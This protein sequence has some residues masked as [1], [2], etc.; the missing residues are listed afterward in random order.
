MKINPII[1]KNQN[2]DKDN[3]KFITH[4]I[5]LL[6]HLQFEKKIIINERLL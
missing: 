4:I 3:R 2:S 6:V 1:W 5:Y